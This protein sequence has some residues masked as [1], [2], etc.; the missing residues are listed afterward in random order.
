MSTCKE[1]FSTCLVL[2]YMWLLALCG[3]RTVYVLLAIELASFLQ[4]L[5]T[6][7]YRKGS[8]E[9]FLLIL[10]FFL[11]LQSRTCRG[12]SEHLG[13][14]SPRHCTDSSLRC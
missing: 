13:T 8:A 6:S 10:L 1:K 5:E 11:F 12:D 14:A 4:V 2:I 7:P 9:I 3:L